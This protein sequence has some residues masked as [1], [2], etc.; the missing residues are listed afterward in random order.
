MEQHWLLKKHK[1]NIELMNMTSKE[2]RWYIHEKTSYKMDD[3][4]NE[5][6]S[7]FDW[8]AIIPH[9]SLFF[10]FE[11]NDVSLPRLFN[12]SRLIE[13]SY[14]LVETKSDLPI[15]KVGI[16]YFIENCVEFIDANMGMGSIM[17]SDDYELLLEFTEDWK[18]TLFSNFLLGGSST[19][20]AAGPDA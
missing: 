16:K 19:P 14:L 18:Y 8:K 13:H 5:F 1:A 9:Y 10:N 12:E 7:V 11:G 20:S 2:L 15:I 4:P 6:N 17:V 3:F